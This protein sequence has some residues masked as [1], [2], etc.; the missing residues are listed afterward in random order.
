MAQNMTESC[1]YRSRNMC[2]RTCGMRDCKRHQHVLTTN[3]VQQTASHLFYNQNVTCINGANITDLLFSKW[4]K[5][6]SDSFEGDQDMLVY[7]CDMGTVREIVCELGIH[8]SLRSK[9]AKLI[10]RVLTDLYYLFCFQ[11]APSVMNVVQ[12]AQRR[13]RAK[14]WARLQG[15]WREP[16][17]CIT[18]SEDPITLTPIDEIPTKEIWSFRDANGHVYAFQAAEIHFSI[19]RL[20]AWNPINRLP[21]PEEDIER[22]ERMMDILPWKRHI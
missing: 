17:V 8:I 22:L 5:F 10:E 18:N 4:K 20:G 2:G 11:Q 7:L 1:S 6:A 21:I 9:K 15:P 12:R 16:G 13:L 14:R 19:F 3:A